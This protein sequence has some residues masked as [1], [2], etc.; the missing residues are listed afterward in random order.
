MNDGCVFFSDTQLSLRNPIVFCLSS[1][2]PL[3]RLPRSVV[4]PVPPNRRPPLLYPRASGTRALTVIQWQ[5]ALSA[6]VGA[7][8]NGKVNAVNVSDD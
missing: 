5:R 8:M 2:C 4:I 1:Q 6:D 7:T 3:I